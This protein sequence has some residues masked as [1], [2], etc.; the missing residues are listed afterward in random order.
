MVAGMPSSSYEHFGLLAFFILL[1]GLLFI[2]WKWPEGKH[3]TFSQH[4]ALHEH[5]I[6]YYI[7]LFSLVLPL[8]LLFFVYWFVPTFQLS[9]WFSIFIIVAS[10][11]QYTCTLIPEVGGWKTKCHRSLAGVSALCL[12]PPLLLLMASDFVTMTGKLLTTL[13]IICMFSIIVAILRSK[14]THSHFLYLQAAYF[15][16]FFAAILSVTYL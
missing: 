2:V 14:G 1:S 15:A 3:L 16:A 5:R 6:L 13:S 10:L 4:V 12:L 8:L 9:Q 7:L 11:T